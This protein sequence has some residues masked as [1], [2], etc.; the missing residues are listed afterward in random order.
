MPPNHKCVHEKLHFTIENTSSVN[1]SEKTKM[2]MDIPYEYPKHLC[3]NDV[4]RVSG[5]Y[6]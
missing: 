2:A 3:N 4:D 6:Q 1:E 5:P